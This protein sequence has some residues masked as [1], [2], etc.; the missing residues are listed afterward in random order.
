MLSL[1]KIFS[2]LALG[3]ILTLRVYT[4]TFDTLDNLG[5][6]ALYVSLVPVAEEKS[7]IRS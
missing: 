2:R 6:D 5:H 4:L 3:I 7:A 1:F